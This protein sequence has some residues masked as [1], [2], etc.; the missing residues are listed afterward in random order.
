M[1]NK[2]AERS[3]SITR[4]V[5]ALG[6]LKSLAEVVLFPPGVLFEAMCAIAFGLDISQLRQADI[7][8]T[9]VFRWH[10]NI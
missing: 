1:I 10:N 8:I 7:F 9:D 2:P 3:G 6:L 5:I 4:L